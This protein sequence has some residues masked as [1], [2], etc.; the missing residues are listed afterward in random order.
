M[1][2]AAMGR[3][4][5]N[6][7]NHVPYEAKSAVHMQGGYKAGYKLEGGDWSWS[8][9]KFDDATQAL[10]AAMQLARDAISMGEK[11]P[12]QEPHS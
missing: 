1:K 3:Q 12:V 10:E 9:E 11:G 2:T 5:R 7:F 4:F 8:T 6:V